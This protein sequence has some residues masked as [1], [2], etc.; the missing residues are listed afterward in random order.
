MVP[1]KRHALPGCSHVSRLL[2]PVLFGLVSRVL[3][4]QDCSISPQDEWKEA[5]E[6]IP[7]M[8]MR[9]QY[10]RG[11][12][13]TTSEEG[14]YVAPKYYFDSACLAKRFLTPPDVH[15][16]LKGR[17][18]IFLGDSLSNQQ[19]DS[20]VGMLGWDPDWMPKGGP[21]N[22]KKACHQRERNG[23]E[24]FTLVD[25][26]HSPEGYIPNIERCYDL[27]DADFSSPD[28][29]L[30]N[31]DKP[32]VTVASPLHASVPESTGNFNTRTRRNRRRILRGEESGAEDGEGAEIE[33]DD[34]GEGTLSVHVR[35]VSLP[36]GEDWLKT[37]VRDYNE[38]R[39]SDVYVVNFG[40][41]YRAYNDDKF[42]RDMF[43]LLDDMAKLGETAT[44]VWREMSP[45]HFP[46]HNGSFDTFVDLGLDNTVCCTGTP[47][48]VLDRNLASIWSWVENYIQDNGLSDRVKI[49]RIYD[50]SVPRGAAHHTCHVAPPSTMNQ[51]GVDDGFCHS[52]YGP[53]CTHW[54]ETGVIEEWNS[55]LLNHICPAE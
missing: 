51:T 31:S 55:L 16:C 32:S 14:S 53:D 21:R 42:K 11:Y 4:W 37:A 41:H 47:P 49:L 27:F 52:N 9:E 25:C 18:V 50:M 35:M 38:T 10:D 1:R 23:T 30:D 33:G 36:T 34:G 28:A 24:Y 22:N 45:V 19:G 17:R 54:S 46:S 20:L 40:A 6:I 12:T 3:G 39:A 15:E 2:A 29:L 26:W 5:T 44:V 13:C 48:K 7:A 8:W 43:S